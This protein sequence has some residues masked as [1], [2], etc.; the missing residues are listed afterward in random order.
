MPLLPDQTHT[1][2]PDQIWQTAL[3]EL[4][5]QLTGA[6]F[7]TWLS[8]TQL[9]A[10]EDGT[11]TIGVHNQYAQD[12]L[13]NRLRAMITRT[14]QGIIGRPVELRFVVNESPVGLP[15]KGVIPI[16]HTGVQLNAPTVNAPTAAG[17]AHR[18][19]PATDLVPEDL[20]WFAISAYASR[21]WRPLLGRVAW[22]VYEIVRESDKRPPKQRTEWTPPRTW[23]A[24]ALA[25]DVPC[26]HQAL[27]G[28]LRG[29][30]PQPGAF[31]R[32][33]ALDVGRVVRQGRDP[34]V[35]YELSVRVML[36]WLA[37]DQVG[38]L[39]ERLRVKH[40]RWKEKRG[41]T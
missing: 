38:Q 6:T 5:L 39:S 13:E 23:T 36:P 26:G 25:E 32:L 3:G 1:L 34:H 14:L 21:F 27:T 17:K 33:A 18:E 10:Y 41:I 16:T 4:A 37:A 30:V 15:L 28:S 8:R 2:A 12:W 7:T 31:D 22:A 40:D 19:E 9:V 20:G 35:V 29:G 11:F 24:P